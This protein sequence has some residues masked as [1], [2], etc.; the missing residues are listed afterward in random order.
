MAIIKCEECGN[1]ISEKAASCP[2][3]GNPITG[4]LNSPVYTVEQTSKKFKLQA[5]LSIVTSCVGLVG[6]FATAENGNTTIPTLMFMG[7]VIWFI[8]NRIRIWWNH[9]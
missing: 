7:G 1:E 2:T 8:V 9:K 4:A 6:M 5:I 3:C